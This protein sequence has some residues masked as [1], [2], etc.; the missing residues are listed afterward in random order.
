MA[1]SRLMDLCQTYRPA[2]QANFTG[3]ETASQRAT[4]AGGRATFELSKSPQSL[5][6]HVEDA[7]WFGARKIGLSDFKAFPQD[8]IM[9]AV[10][11]V[12]PAAE[13]YFDVKY[14][15]G[16]LYDGEVAIESD[17]WQWAV[18]VTSGRSGSALV[19]MKDLLCIVRPKRV[20][21]EVLFY[22]V[23]A[24]TLEG[25]S[26]VSL[27]VQR[28]SRDFGALSF[29]IGRP[30]SGDLLSVRYSIVYF[31][32][33]TVVAEGR[34]NYSELGVGRYEKTQARPGTYEI[35][36]R[37][38][39]GV[40]FCRAVVMPSQMT[41]VEL[42]WDVGA[43]I[44]VSVTDATGKPI[45]GAVVRYPSG[46]YTVFPAGRQL[47]GRAQLTD[48]SG[49]A[50]LLAVAPVPQEFVV[51]AE[52]FEVGEVQVAPAAA[53]FVQVTCV[54]HPAKGRVSVT[55]TNALSPGFYLISY[56]RPMN[57]GARLQD[58]KATAAGSLALEGLPR[59]AYTFVVRGAE[60]GPVATC[61]VD[62]SNANG[63]VEIA[64]DVAKLRPFLE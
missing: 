62:L 53:G 54:L 50:K 28:M 58:I 35:T 63:I 31:P 23:R 61:D 45:S 13:L 15:D 26:S 24:A 8:E 12:V 49:T 5:S 34:L 39:N 18:R 43:T 14:E 17:A 9:D 51:E 20:G 21:Y 29:T 33:P 25:T 41:S 57:G 40:A 44:L 36:V 38:G 32:G 60:N 46:A 16:E 59:R 4:D 7:K 42:E 11:E 52:G 48:S 56:I 64:I 30:A 55:L 47:G 1:F 2:S 3:F 22:V 10:I 19:P 37:S 27:T 6:A